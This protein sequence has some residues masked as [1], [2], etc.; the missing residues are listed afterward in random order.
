MVKGRLPPKI[1]LF[2]SIHNATRGD[3]TRT[4]LATLA[5]DKSEAEQARQWRKTVSCVLLSVS[6]FA[7]VVIVSFGLLWNAL[8]AGMPV[9]P[10]RDQLWALNRVP[11]VEFLDSSGRTISVRGPRYGRAVSALELPPHVVN[12]FIAA[13]DGR[14][15]EHSGIDALGIVRALIRNVRAGHTVEGGSTITQQLVKNL[16]L[17][18]DQTIQRKAQEAKLAVELEGVLSKNEIL[19]LYL[20]RIYFGDGA[21]GLGAAAYAYFGKMPADLNLS[22]AAL[23]AALPKAPS[24]FASER[25]GNRLRAR[26]HYVLDRMA[27]DG[28]VS[29][30]Q[31]EAAKVAVMQF[32]PR[33]ST[34]N[35]NYALDFAML[36]LRK[37]LPDPPPDL[38][39]KLSVDIVLQNASN[40]AMAQELAALNGG[41]EGAVVV[42]DRGGAIRA[43]VGGRDYLRSPFNRA[44]QARRQSGSAFKMFV[45]AAALEAGLTARTFCIDEPTRIDDWQPRNYRDKYIGQVTLTQALTQSLNTV[46]AQIG[47]KI[48]PRKVADLAHRFGIQSS[49]N[50]F[51][52][53]SLGTD[54]VTLLEMTTGYGVLN[55]NGL[56]MAPYVIE[57]IHNSKG[58]LLY[59]RPIVAEHRVFSAHAAETM[60]GML[61]RVVTAGT[62][63]QAQVKGWDVAG[64]TGTSQNSRDA[65][66]F[67]YTTQFVAGVWIGMDDATS[68]DQVTG[69]AAPARVFAN[70]MTSA[71]AGLPIE[72]LPTVGDEELGLDW[73]P[74]LFE[75]P[76]VDPVGAVVSDDAGAPAGEALPL[77][78]KDFCSSEDIGLALAGR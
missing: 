76:P 54:E 58:D 47:T 16:L 23:L 70:L 34:N 27:S 40:H 29:S 74:P 5:Q 8:F 12:A 46:A 49:L 53:I 24:L 1:V 42:I 64:K 48:G 2:M 13:E 30:A 35:A 67:G 18:Q 20:N 59:S 17:D 21:Y 75:M 33:P 36:Q 9:L 55:K 72:R 50:G 31:S 78:A 28:F 41:E 11:A 6:I 26:Q 51:P 52:S 37:L 45:Y 15:R 73:V 14:F 63:Q 7:V 3:Y 65:W 25:E 66:F 60:T 32:A 56:E 10:S 38:V 39:V 19:D 68:M 77:A 61:Q 71:L 57:E 22:E 43:M 4:G 44:T 69:G 62:G